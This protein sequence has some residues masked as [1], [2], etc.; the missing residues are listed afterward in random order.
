MDVAP[1]APYPYYSEQGIM[2]RL[3][4]SVGAFS[5]LDSPFNRSSFTFGSVTAPC[6]P[7]DRPCL[8]YTLF[9]ALEARVLKLAGNTHSR[10]DTDHP[11][12][13][14][15]MLP[16]AMPP[17]APEFVITATESHLKLFIKP[18]CP[19]ADS[20]HPIQLG[21]GGNTISDSH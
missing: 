19:K 8:T 17:P 12:P 6:V 15:D 4:S 1:V 21:S 13:Q 16:Q 9:P 2:L 5:P 20:D 10:Q 11:C 18:P 7:K 14:P 3:R